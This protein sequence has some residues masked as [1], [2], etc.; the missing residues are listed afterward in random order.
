MIREEQIQIIATIQEVVS[1]HYGLTRRQLLTGGRHGDYV[2]ARHASMYL[3]RK[4]SGARF[5]MIA[6]MFNRNQVTAQYA[7]H[8]VRGMLTRA[9]F[10]ADMD[11]IEKKVM[12][13]LQ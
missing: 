6:G 12:A 3:S 8:K 9:P 5:N 10:K 13:A 4:L 11:F 2:K 1:K 7:F